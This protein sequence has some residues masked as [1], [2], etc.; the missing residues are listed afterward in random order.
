MAIANFI[1]KVWSANLISVLQKEHV[2]A[3]VA[4]RDYEGDISGAGDSV[5]ISQIGTITVAT[6]T[7]N[8]T[9][10][11]PQELQDAAST[12]LIDQS[13]YFA[14]KIDDVDA[15]QAKPKVMQEAMKQAA[16]ALADTQDTYI[17][18]LYGQ[19]GLQLGTSLGSTT[20]I[21]MTSLNVEDS[22]LAAGE[23]MDNNSIPRSGRFSVIAPWIQTKLVLAGIVSLS[24]NTAVYTNGQLGRALGFDFSVSANVS[25]NSSSWDITR[26]ICGVKGQSLTV[27]EQI[28]K[29]EAFRP[30][31]QFSDAVKGL[32][33]YGCK[34]IRPDMTL[35]LYA[36][37]TAEA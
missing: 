16:Y 27:A 6:Y 2:F 22:F 33:V 14:F 4:N 31:A 5:K 13:K 35:C 21:D 24:D 11:S 10:V 15:A 28:V 17:A 7:R 9:S 34:V 25:K 1:P 29:T 26:V 20:P 30:E 18:G 37:K 32:H 12:L 8:S 3:N 36:D 19:A 23:A